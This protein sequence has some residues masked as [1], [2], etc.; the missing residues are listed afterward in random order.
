MGVEVYTQTR[1]LD[2][3]GEI[4]HLKDKPS[5]KTKTVIWSAGVTS[6]QIEGFKLD[7]YGRGNRLIVDRSNKIEAY[8]HIYALGDI[9]IMSTPKYKDGHPQLANVAIGQAKLLAKNLSRKS[10]GKEPLPYEYIDL[11]TMATL[12]KNKAVVELPFIK[13]KGFF[14]WLTWMFLHLML[15]LNVKN[16]IIIFI[17]WSWTYFTKNTTLGL[18]LTKSEINK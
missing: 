8:N 13:F 16:K 14:A 4:L 2:Y 7:D 15:I 18:I 11:G 12:G 1:V 9:S 3:D 17:D 10:K 5:L 6:N